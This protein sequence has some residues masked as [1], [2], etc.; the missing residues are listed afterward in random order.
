MQLLLH[1]GHKLLRL[2]PRH[3]CLHGAVLLGLEKSDD[4]IDVV[5]V[6]LDGVEWCRDW[7]NELKDKS[8]NLLSSFSI[9]NRN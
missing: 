6:K 1:V 4:F 3:D 2:W 5:R 8:D 9:F 7:T